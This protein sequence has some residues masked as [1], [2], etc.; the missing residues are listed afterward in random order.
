MGGKINGGDK[1]TVL[2][3]AVKQIELELITVGK[4]SYHLYSP[5]KSLMTSVG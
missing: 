3:S 4:M 2:G 5:R 1:V